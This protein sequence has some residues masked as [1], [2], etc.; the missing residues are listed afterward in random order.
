[1]FFFRFPSVA[2]LECDIGQTE[3]TVPGVVGLY[4]LTKPLLGPAYTHPLPADR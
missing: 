3:F 4:V 1:M 2:Y